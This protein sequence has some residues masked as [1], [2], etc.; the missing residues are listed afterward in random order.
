M[1]IN[2]SIYP[3]GIAEHGTTL[4][5]PQI[6]GAAKDVASVKG[7]VSSDPVSVE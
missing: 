1:Y 4:P 2:Y 5:K 7:T 6:R 3:D